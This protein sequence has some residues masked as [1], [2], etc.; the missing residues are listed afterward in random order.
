[1]TGHP[2]PYTDVRE[3]IQ[4]ETTVNTLP[5]PEA[6]TAEIA[7]LQAIKPRVRHYTLFGDD[8]HAAIDAQIELLMDPDPE[9][10][11]N[12]YSIENDEHIYFAVSE[13]LEW[14]RGERDEPP[15]VDWADLTTDKR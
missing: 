5:T 11:I 8:N 10:A 15:S 13:A 1:V 3:T 4:G 6:I 7:A 9:E 14:L 12:D 2:A